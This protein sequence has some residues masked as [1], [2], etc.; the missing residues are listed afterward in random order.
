[1]QQAVRSSNGWE[2]EHANPRMET[3]ILRWE[4]ERLILGTSDGHDADGADEEL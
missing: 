1:M 2:P 4:A 3:E